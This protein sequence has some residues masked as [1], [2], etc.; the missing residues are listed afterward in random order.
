MSNSRPHCNG[1][2]SARFADSN[3]TEPPTAQQQRALDAVKVLTLIKKVEAL[4]P[5]LPDSVKEASTDDNELHLLTNTSGIQGSPWGTLNRQLDKLFGVD[6]L[7]DGGLKH[8]RRGEHGMYFVATHLAGL[9]W[10]SGKYPLDLVELKLQR[11][12]EEMEYFY[13]SATSAEIEAAQP[14]KAK[15]PMQKRPDATGGKG[16]DKSTET[17]ASKTN[18]KSTAAKFSEKSAIM[19]IDSDQDDPDYTL[20]KRRPR[21]LSDEEEDDFTMSDVELPATPVNPRKR[22]VLVT[23]GSVA[24]AKPVDAPKATNT[25]VP[26][27]HQVIE[28]EDDDDVPDRK[29]GKR[30]PKSDTRL[31][32]HEPIA[33]TS[34][35]SMRWEFGC[36][37]CKSSFTF[38]RSVFRNSSFE[39]EPTKPKLGNLSTHLKSHG[40]VPL[41][42][43]AKLGVPR[44]VSAASAKIMEEFLKDGKLNPQYVVDEGEE[45]GITR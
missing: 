31:H 25:A 18:S 11:I 37:H 39:D 29:R 41:P 32:F 12:V 19:A 1:F 26:A 6:T 14:L 22:K 9:D 3:N 20:P 5:L 36:R 15:Q 35:G 23:K 13:L 40:D 30:G 42:D 2:P 4:A 44:N 34:S 43:D 27:P 7:E 17:V 21:N 33:V 45:A 16:P 8:I 38:A 28:I 24:A 10:K